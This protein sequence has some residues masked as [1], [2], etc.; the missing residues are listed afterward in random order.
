MAE[1]KLETK[2]MNGKK[3]IRYPGDDFWQEVES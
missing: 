2:I 3:Y 1:R